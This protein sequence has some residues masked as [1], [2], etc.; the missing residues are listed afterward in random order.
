LL[1]SKL[2]NRQSEISASH[3]CRLQVG[4]R[5]LKSKLANRQSPIANL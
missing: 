3:L 1:K 4:F 2:A 5:L